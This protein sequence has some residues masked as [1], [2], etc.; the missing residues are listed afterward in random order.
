MRTRG[1]LIIL[2]LFATALV[3]KAD[4]IQLK[5][6]RKI[7]CDV[8][9][10]EGKLLR[11]WI[12]DSALSVPMERVER[13]ERDDETADELQSKQSG[14]EERIKQLP[15]IGLS[16]SGLGSAPVSS[17]LLSRLEANVRAAPGDKEQRQRLVNALLTAAYLQ[18][19]AGDIRRRLA[20]R[21]QNRNSHW[22]SRG[23]G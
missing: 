9:R 15:E 18:Y 2:F 12:G 16:R 10:Q 20:S 17:E 6:G 8:A 14:V 5:D 11:Y 23:A 4:T 22:H 21:S 13:V 19:Q 3:V 7:K 1:L